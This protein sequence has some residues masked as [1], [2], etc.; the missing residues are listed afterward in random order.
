MP[1]VDLLRLFA[2]VTNQNVWA[3]ALVEAIRSQHA[4]STKAILRI[5]PDKSIYT[6]RQG[7]CLW[8]PPFNTSLLGRIFEEAIA[9]DNVEVFKVILNLTN[10]PNYKIP[11]FNKLLGSTFDGDHSL[12]YRAALDKRKNIAMFLAKHPDLNVNEIGP[13]YVHNESDPASSLD[14]IKGIPG[15]ESVYNVLLMQHPQS[16]QI[17]QTPKTEIPKPA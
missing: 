12:L 1:I 6:K 8:N 13:Q 16:P 14:L 9:T 7:P 17:P 4:P 11:Y 10:D 2:E 3:G 5:V 15:M